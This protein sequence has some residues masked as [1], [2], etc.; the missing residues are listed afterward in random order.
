MVLGDVGRGNRK[1]KDISA[2][3]RTL[4]LARKRNKLSQEFPLDS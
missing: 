2:R 1:T 4:S 3:A